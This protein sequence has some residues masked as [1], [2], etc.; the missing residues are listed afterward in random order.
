MADGVSEYARIYGVTNEP[1]LGDKK[2]GLTPT[3]DL[4]LWFGD[5]GTWSSQ[6]H[7]RL[8]YYETRSMCNSSHAPTR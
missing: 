4:T 7:N 6:C 8:W 2:S 3:E 1:F 5:Q